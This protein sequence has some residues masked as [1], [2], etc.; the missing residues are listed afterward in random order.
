MLQVPINHCCKAGIALEKPVYCFLNPKVGLDN[1]VWV[2]F[3][4]DVKTEFCVIKS[5]DITDQSNQS[6][7]RRKKKVKVLSLPRHCMANSQPPENALI[8]GNKQHGELIIPSAAIHLPKGL[9]QVRI[10]RKGMMQ[11]RYSKFYTKPAEHI[12]FANS[13]SEDNASTVTI[14]SK[15][16]NGTENWLKRGIDL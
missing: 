16:G 2:D 13:K 9:P 14:Y 6:V 3:Y 15:H 12:E 1:P 7:L 11:S 4:E 5:I 10:V 8:S